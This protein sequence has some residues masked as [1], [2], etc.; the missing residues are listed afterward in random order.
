MELERL[1]SLAAIVAAVVWLVF[2]VPFW[3]LLRKDN[4]FDEVDSPCAPPL[5]LSCRL[6]ASLPPP[7]V[8][9]PRRR[10]A[11]RVERTP[12]ALH[13]SRVR[14]AGGPGRCALAS[15]ADGRQRQR[16]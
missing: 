13:G 5:P 12:A 14:S 11:L 4:G 16:G 10:A 2:S 3:C 6:P 7:S 1:L 8:A 15:A 9:P